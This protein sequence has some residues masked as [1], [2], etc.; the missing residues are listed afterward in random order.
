MIAEKRKS[1]GGELVVV[2][3]WPDALGE[4]HARVARRSLTSGLRKRRASVP[5]GATLPRRAQE[6]L[7]T[8]GADRRSGTTG[9]TAPLERL[10][11][12]RRRRP[13]RPALLRGRALGRGGERGACQWP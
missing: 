11:L 5:R 9:G 8:R 12:G 10:P 4:L 6:R 13:R 7:A 2:E 1:G 3:R